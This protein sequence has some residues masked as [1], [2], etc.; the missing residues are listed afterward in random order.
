M[1]AVRA[2]G[3]LVERIL[4]ESGPLPAWCAEQRKLAGIVA[5]AL[6]APPRDGAL[7]I[8]TQAATGTGKTIALLAPLMAL[9]ALPD[10]AVARGLDRTSSGTRLEPL[11]SNGGRFVLHS[12]LEAARM[13]LRGPR[14]SRRASDAEPALEICGAPSTVASK[15]APGI[16]CFPP[17]VTMSRRMKR[18]T[19]TIG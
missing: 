11:E 12:T 14:Q 19:L 10:A 18:S 15:R 6:D 5:E 1:A 13:W 4:S 8:L 3:N 9:A 7:V 2:V 16:C 17:S